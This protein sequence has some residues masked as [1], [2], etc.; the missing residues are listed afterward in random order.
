MK[1][2]RLKSKRREDGVDTHPKF[3]GHQRNFS[4]FLRVVVVSALAVGPFL[5]SLNGEFVFDDSATILNNPVVNG[6]G[7]IKQVFSTDYWGH[8]IASLNS[9]KSYRPLT[10][11]TFW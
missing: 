5:P 4:S 8:P 11:F 10:T 6:R 7:S 2:G 9:H 3:Y 1:R